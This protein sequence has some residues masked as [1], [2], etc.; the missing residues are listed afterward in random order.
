MPN[1]DPALKAVLEKVGGP[2]KLGAHLGVGASAVTQWDKVP[3]RHVPRV[4][5]VTGFSGSF[6]R[7]DLYEPLPQSER[8]SAA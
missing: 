2:T 3:A 5:A 1:Y 4:A 7:P 6:I 8:A